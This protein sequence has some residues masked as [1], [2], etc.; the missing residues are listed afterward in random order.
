M[1][2]S[3]DGYSSKNTT[4]QV[5]YLT[6]DCFEEIRVS[7]GYNFGKGLN[8]ILRKYIEHLVV[9]NYEILETHHTIEFPV[10]PISSGGPKEY[11]ERFNAVAE[12]IMQ[13]VE[14]LEKA[15]A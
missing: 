14:E 5:V 6:P 9:I 2:K 13:Q 7:I 1:S 3:V 11:R 8:V 10:K 15:P 4:V 12:R